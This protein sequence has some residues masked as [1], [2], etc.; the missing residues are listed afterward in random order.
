[1][2]PVEQFPCVYNTVYTITDA[3]QELGC[4]LE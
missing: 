1:M 2:A 4:S 3:K